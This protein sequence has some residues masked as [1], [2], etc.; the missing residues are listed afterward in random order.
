VKT[1]SQGVFSR[2]QHGGYLEEFGEFEGFEKKGDGAQS[3]SSV[4]MSNFLDA[5]KNDDL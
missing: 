1:A 4:Y 3:V 5:G 2:V